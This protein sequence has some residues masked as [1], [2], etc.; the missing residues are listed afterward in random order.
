MNYT[1]KRKR[2]R[3]K[4]N[5]IGCGKIN[6]RGNFCGETFTNRE[7]NKTIDF[8]HMCSLKIVRQKEREIIARKLKKRFYDYW[9]VRETEEM[10]DYHYDDF[11]KI[12]NEE[13][14]I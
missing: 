3:P 2:G 1:N 5:I 7:G 14:K 6:E 13:C 10:D 8:C 11:E 12:I 9:I 4:S